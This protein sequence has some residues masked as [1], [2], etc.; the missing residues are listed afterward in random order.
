MLLCSLPG[1]LCPGKVCPN[2]KEGY[3]REEQMEL[4]WMVAASCLVVESKV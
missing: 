4:G 1:H 3:R 2:G